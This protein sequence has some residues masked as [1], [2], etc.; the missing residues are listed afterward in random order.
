MASIFTGS[1]NE[2]FDLALNLFNLENETSFPIVNLIAQNFPQN[3]EPVIKTLKFDDC[4]DSTECKISSFKFSLIDGIKSLGWSPDGQHLAFAAQ[5]DDLSSDIYV[6]S[7]EDKTTS[8]LTNEPG[9]IFRIIWSPNGQK[10]LYD[11]SIEG[12]GFSTSTIWHLADFTT[13]I[14]QKSKILSGKNSWRSL[15]W[16]NEDLFFISTAID[17]PV[18]IDTG[19]IDIDSKETKI[20]WPYIT[21]SMTLDSENDRIILSFMQYDINNPEI[22]A[23]T[24]LL[25]LDGAFT[26]ITNEIFYLFP[27][28]ISF[29]SYLAMDK[30]SS[31]VSISPHGSITNFAQ[32]VSY[33]N[34]PRV[35]PD[36]RWII[37]R[38]D[39]VTK[40][41]SKNIQLIK[42]WDIDVSEVIWRTDSRG[43]FLYDRDKLYYLTIP[44]GT[45]TSIDFCIA[46][47]CQLINYVWLP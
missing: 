39:N 22:T 40:L 31:L 28:Q 5:I 27:E 8:R 45:P 17:S 14:L 26:K 16:F 44:D 35:S 23:G 1:T 43:A 33:Q 34:T 32:T 12:G 42:S 9:N 10:V 38:R 21:E 15:G 46:K 41:F 13:T 2:P 19:Y 37:I 3:L 24:Y 47:S 4:I 6:F 11:T 7:M 20:I 18:Y 30:N 29:D 36:K 25:Y